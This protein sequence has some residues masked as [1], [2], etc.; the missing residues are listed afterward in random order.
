MAGAVDKGNDHRNER[1]DRPLDA[2]EDRLQR[3]FPRHLQTAGRRR[4]GS[5]HHHESSGSSERNAIGAAPE[6]M[7]HRESPWVWVAGIRRSSPVTGSSPSTRASSARRRPVPTRTST[8]MR[9]MA[10]GRASCWARGYRYMLNTVGAGL[11]KKKQTR[12]PTK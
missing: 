3:S 9:V 2:L 11:L 1:V 8:A 7:D 6:G 4:G 5:G 12:N 10:I